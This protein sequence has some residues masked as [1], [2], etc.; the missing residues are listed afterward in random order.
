MS[1]HTPSSLWLSGWRGASAADGLAGIWCSC[2]GSSLSIWG[3]GESSPHTCSAPPGSW[4]NSVLSKWLASSGGSHCSSLLVLAAV[5]SAKC[6][7]QTFT[8]AHTCHYFWYQK[9]TK[10]LV[11][12]YKQTSTRGSENFFKK[13]QKDMKGRLIFRV[14][15]N[16]CLRLFRYGETW[17]KPTETF[18]WNR[19]EH[20]QMLALVL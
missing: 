15:A 8:V 12:L 10:S 7:N 6:Q 5:L 9:S 19:A 2:F 1:P 3:G 18:W 20:K 17:Q 14:L 4:V 13:K 16:T 11:F